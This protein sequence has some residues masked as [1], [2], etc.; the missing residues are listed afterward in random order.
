MAAAELAGY[1]LTAIQI[2]QDYPR[3]G[4]AHSNSPKRSFR[5][6]PAPAV[7]SCSE[8]AASIC[9][10]P[11]AIQANFR[12]TCEAAP[13][14]VDPDHQP[15]QPLFGEERR[16]MNVI[17]NAWEEKAF[18]KPMSVAKTRAATGRRDRLRTAPVVAGQNGSGRGVRN[19]QRAG[20]ETENRGARLQ[21][22]QQFSDL[23]SRRASRHRSRLR[24][25]RANL[26]KPAMDR[27]SMDI[28]R[29]EQRREC[30]NETGEINEFCHLRRGAVK[31]AAA[32]DFEGGSGSAFSDGTLNGMLRANRRRLNWRSPM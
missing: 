18:L 21:I 25:A 22:I 16:R 7:V 10:C 1:V 23:I 8:T 12:R 13:P 20:N 31:M 32:G 6:R 28:W 24:P 5:H 11:K 9:Q 4:P 30:T 2:W 15:L 27:C 29:S 14:Q 3:P 26:E 17:P 19:G